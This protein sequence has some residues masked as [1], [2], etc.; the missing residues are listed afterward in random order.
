MAEYPALVTLDAQNTSNDGPADPTKAQ[1]AGHNKIDEN[2]KAIAD[3]L[4]AAFDSES[5]ADVAATIAKHRVDINALGN[6][7]VVSGSQDLTAGTPV[8]LD[9]ISATKIKRIRRAK[10]WISANGADVGANVVTRV[11]LKFFNTDGFLHAQLDT[12]GAEGLIED[13]GEFQFTSQDI[14]VNS[15][16][17]DGT[18]DIDDTV[19]FGIDDLIRIHD[20]TNFEYQRV[21]A[22]TDADTL[23]LYD[24]ILKAGTPAWALNDDVTRVLEIRDIGYTDQDAS[25]E[26]HLRIIPRAGDDNCRLHFWIE[27]E[28]GT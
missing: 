18:I 27:F 25:N 24:T 15:N 23:D 10:F 17:G 2:V 26:I 22:V 5:V 14:A 4:K 28:K 6:T 20:G 3:D 13:F 7:F 12:E 19:N 8:N 1:A 21:T 9:I 11:Q 16:N